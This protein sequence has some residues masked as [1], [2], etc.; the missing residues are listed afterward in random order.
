MPDQKFILTICSSQKSKHPASQTHKKAFRLVTGKD[1]EEEEVR[2]NNSSIRMKFPSKESRFNMWRVKNRNNSCHS[3][4][5]VLEKEWQ[6]K[7]EKEMS[8]NLI[9]F[10]LLL[11]PLTNNNSKNRSPDLIDEHRCKERGFAWCIFLLFDKSLDTKAC[12]ENLVANTS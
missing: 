10:A 1:E 5:P 8:S 12:S 2:D 6:T 11:I 4:V 9:K 3:A 7:R